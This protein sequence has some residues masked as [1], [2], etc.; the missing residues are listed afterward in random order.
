MTVTFRLPFHHH[1]PHLQPMP[2]ITTR[3]CGI[4]GAPVLYASSPSLGWHPIEYHDCKPVPGA[5]LD[6]VKA[7]LREG[8]DTGRHCCADRADCPRCAWE[9]KVRN[10]LE[11][12]RGFFWKAPP[13]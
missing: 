8:L 7:L 10:L 6:A 11:V 5:Q 4:C 13:L 12:R 2:D 1:L 3:S 9:E